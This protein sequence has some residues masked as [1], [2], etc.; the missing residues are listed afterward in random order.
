MSPTAA[1]NPPTQNKTALDPELNIYTV[2]FSNWANMQGRGPLYPL[3]NPRMSNKNGNLNA[4][5]TAVAEMETIK[6][7]DRCLMIRAFP[8]ALTAKQV[9]LIV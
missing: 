5:F 4:G 1:H 6:R 7:N 9:D 2:T 8:G 3:H